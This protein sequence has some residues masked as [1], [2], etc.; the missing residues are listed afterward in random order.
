M[1]LGDNFL[2]IVQLFRTKK[3]HIAPRLKTRTGFVALK[4]RHQTPA[5]VTELHAHKTPS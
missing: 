4:L 5:G 3:K 1:Y 2:F